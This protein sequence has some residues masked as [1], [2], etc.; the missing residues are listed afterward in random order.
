M[1]KIPIKNQETI[2]NS[3]PTIKKEKEIVKE[4]EKNI[5]K[6]VVTLQPSQIRKA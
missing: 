3:I 5:T 4:K 1:K 6:K 2:F